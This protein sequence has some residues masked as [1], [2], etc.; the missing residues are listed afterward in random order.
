MANRIH[1][2]ILSILIISINAGN[3]DI[4]IKKKVENAKFFG[5][6]MSGYNNKKTIL[7]T[8]K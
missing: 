6:M 2:T 7:K 8:D 4:K 5:V 3:K 1:L